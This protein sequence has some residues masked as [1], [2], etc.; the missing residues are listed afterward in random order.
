MVKVNSMERENYET[1]ADMRLSAGLV[2][3]FFATVWRLVLTLYRSYCDPAPIQ[4]TPERLRN[5]SIF[6]SPGQSLL[7]VAL[8]VC[9]VR[10]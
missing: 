8:L 5:A 1:K 4:R 7:V 10:S 3:E 6:K 2:S 9:F